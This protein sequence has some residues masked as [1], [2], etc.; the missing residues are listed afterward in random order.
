LDLTKTQNT[1]ESSKEE[2]QVAIN[3][4]T[5]GDFFN[6]LI[7]NDIKQ[8][9]SIE[10]IRTN[11]VSKSDFESLKTLIVELLSKDTLSE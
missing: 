10:E 11:M 8:Q 2:I 3:T 4:E 6:L 7:K 9:D 5:V 1:T